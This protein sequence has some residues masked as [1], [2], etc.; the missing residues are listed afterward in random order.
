MIT[1]DPFLSQSKYLRI[2]PCGI[3]EN[4][5]LRVYHV[6]EHSIQLAIHNE[7]S[8]THRFEMRLSDHPMDVGSRRVSVGLVI[9]DVLSIIDGNVG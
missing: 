2:P 7:V 4:D 9:L 1:D 5:I 6:G 3:G 8:V